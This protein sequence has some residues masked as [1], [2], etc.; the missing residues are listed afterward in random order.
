MPYLSTCAFDPASLGHLT[1]TVKLVED[2]P[3]VRISTTELHAFN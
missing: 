2:M 1:E 3:T